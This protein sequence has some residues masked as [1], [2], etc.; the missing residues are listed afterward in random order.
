MRVTTL[1]ATAASVAATAVIGGLASRPAVRS[2][3][4]ARLRTPSFQPPPQVFPVVWP[5][6][7]T[8]IALVSAPTID[9]LR[10][11]GQWRQARAYRTALAVNL[12]LNGSWSWIFFNRHQLGAAAAVAA[13]LT[14]SSADLTRRA[15][16]V[17]GVQAAPLALYPL[18]CAFATVL[19]TRIW[20]LNRRP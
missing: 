4:Y 5:T 2:P 18:W 16:A 13:A 6:L 14:A 1:A 3:W 7:Y 20:L 9:Q 12:V 11:R 19:S 17:R 10:D 15:V 8:D